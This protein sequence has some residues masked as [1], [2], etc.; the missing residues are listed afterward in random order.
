MIAAAISDFREHITKYLGFISKGKEIVIT[1][2]GKEI[3]RVLP[4]KNKKNS[5]RKKLAELSK[6]A[7]IKN[8]T[9]PVSV[10]WKMK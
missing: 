8:I 1:S 7:V 2:H 10:E 4:P 5:A 9:D 3:A 6:T